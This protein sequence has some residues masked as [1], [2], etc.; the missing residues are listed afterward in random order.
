LQLGLNENTN[1]LLSQYWPKHKD[2]KQLTP[3]AEASVIASLK[4]RGQERSSV[5]KRRLIKWLNTWQ[6]LPF[7]WLCTSRLNSPSDNLVIFDI[8]RYNGDSKKLFSAYFNLGS[9]NKLSQSN[10]NADFKIYFK[11]PSA[12]KRPSFTISGSG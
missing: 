2:F 7:N 3:R 12:S 6:H 10:Q 9:I 11:L 8:S 1:G 4:T 5:I